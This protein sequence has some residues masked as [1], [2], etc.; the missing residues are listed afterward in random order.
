MW[1]HAAAM[2]IRAGVVFPAAAADTI[3]F[4]MED[5]RGCAIEAAIPFFFY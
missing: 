2:L 4:H 5:K 1:T 3:L